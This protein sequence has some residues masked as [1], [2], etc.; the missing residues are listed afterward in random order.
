MK[1]SKVSNLGAGWIMSPKVGERRQEK[2]QI[3]CGRG[4]G[5]AP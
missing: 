4:E 5:S 1:E 2:E 3:S